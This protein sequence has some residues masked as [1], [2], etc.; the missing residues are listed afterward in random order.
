MASVALCRLDRELMRHRIS[1][2]A[3]EW[4]EQATD[5]AVS[6]DDPG[7]PDDGDCY[8][9]AGSANRC[10]AVAGF[11]SHGD[12]GEGYRYLTELLEMLSDEPNARRLKRLVSV[13]RDIF[14]NPFRQVA[15]E[16]D[17]LTSNV[18]ALARQMYEGRDFAAMPILADAL[19]DAGCDND[20]ILTHCR[21]DGPHVRGCWVV[22]LILGKE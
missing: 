14:G 19:Q 7:G 4:A 3:V 22:D 10:L 20:D 16:S 6:F 15:V 18:V 17:W 12:A 2:H 1:R 8:L 9:M 11:A 13:C 5:G 21:G